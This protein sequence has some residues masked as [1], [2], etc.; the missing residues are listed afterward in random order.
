MT[1]PILFLIFNRPDLV[2]ISFREIRKAKPSQLFVAADGPRAIKEGEAELCEQARRIVDHV[3][4]ECEIHTLFRDENLGCRK[5]V[6]S[7]ISWFFDH[8][9]DGIILE[10]DCVPEHSFFR[11]CGDMLARYR[12]DERVMCVTGDNFQD[13]I[14]RGRASY[15][16]SIYNHCWGW[17][18]WRRAW[19][20]FDHDLKNWERL[21]ETRFLQKLMP[22]KS[23]DYWTRAFDSVLTNKVDSWAYIWTFSCWSQNGVTAT[24]NQNLVSNIGFDTRATHTADATSA[25]SRLQSHQIAFPLS[26]PSRVRRNRKADRY[27]EKNSFGIQLPDSY[28]DRVQRKL[29]KLVSGTKT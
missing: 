27:V 25:S 22:R 4:W 7:A 18:T 6:S 26:H 3:D 9:E 13:G 28:S 23:A 21:R 1:P 20:H 14:A 15:Y 5:A 11:F 19:N 17:A 8:V 16:F 2:E 12:N 29:K 24:P 10:D